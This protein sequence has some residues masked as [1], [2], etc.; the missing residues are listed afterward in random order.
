[1]QIRLPA[2]H[3]LKLG[4]PRLGF[5]RPLSSLP[6]RPPCPLGSAPNPWPIATHPVIQRLGPDPSLRRHY[7]NPFAAPDTLQHPLLELVGKSP[8]LPFRHGP[9]SE[10]MSLSQP[11]WIR[12]ADL[13]VSLITN[14]Q[15]WVNAPVCRKSSLKIPANMDMRRSTSLHI[16]LRV[17][18]PALNPHGT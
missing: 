14:S 11:F 9:S 13:S 17:S 7:S 18:Y 1:M 3:A 8:R 2:D 5:G 16:L 15:C 4:D 10:A 12:F 6:P